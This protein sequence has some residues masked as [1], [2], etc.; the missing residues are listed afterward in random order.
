MAKRKE[1]SCEE[2]MA[3]ARRRETL[4]QAAARVSRNVA[5]I[6][7]PDQLLEQTVDLICDEF[8]FYYAGVFLI[9]ETGEW[10]VLRAGRGEPGRK[11][12]EAGHKLKVDGHSM[13]GRATGERR[14]LIALDVG[15]EPVH[16]KN[17]YLPNTH[18]EMALPLIV[19][20]EL[21]GA[22]TVQS[23]EIAA[24]TDDDIVVLQGM[25]DQLAIAIKNARLHQENQRL[26]ARA[27]RRA[28]L[29]EA[30]AQV[31]RDATSILDLDELLNK[32][33]DIICDAYGFYYAGVF[34]VDESGEWAVLRAG[35]G[36]AG[37]KMIEAGHRLKVGGLSMIGTAIAQRKARIALDV[38]EE[39]VHF[40]NPY[41]PYTRSE[42]ALPLVIGD[43]VIGAITVQSMEEA[44]FSDEDIASLQA[45]ADQVAVAIRNA[46][47]LKDLEE[48]HKELVRTKT[49]EAIATSTLEAIHWIGNKALPITAS[50]E[51]LR[52]D[53]AA[54]REVDAE[55]VNSMME[56]LEIIDESAHLIFQVREHIIGPA[57]EV[58]PGPVMAE[59]VLR[60]AAIALGV[61]EAIITWH[62]AETVPRVWADPLHLSR[63][64]TY[65]LKNALEA[66]EG[67]ESPQIGVE[68][69]PAGNFVAV[70]ITDNGPA[71]PEEVLDKI[72]VP[73]FTTKGRRH[74]GLGLSATMQIIRQLEGK[75]R[76]EN[77][78]EGGVRVEL[79]MPLYDG[80]EPEVE[81][82]EGLKVLLLDD[83]DPWSR[84]AIETWEE[85]ENEVKRATV[86]EK[87]ERYDL[88]IIDDVMAEG[89]SVQL[90]RDLR[91]SGAA[92][93]TVVVA[94][95]L[96]PEEATRLLQYGA[97]DVRPKPYSEAGLAALLSEA[98]PGI[99]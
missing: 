85:A 60:D 70:R 26:L 12:I 74:A 83:D 28:R 72:W 92:R 81:M 2:E 67:M 98:E 78:P 76:V 4:L 14:A 47:L 80:R 33:V 66:V 63:A 9:D 53:L 44:A 5:S 61:D 49:F 52:E 17:P 50:V 99:V 56:D 68:I 91:R 38:G 11:M 37:R 87:P 7:D 97:K 1:R 54:F 95:R 19:G 71:I 77:L 64:F 96:G 90:L 34:L 82:A 58:K 86:L 57:R 43:Q 42:M 8:G 13:I 41:L 51:G 29:L 6:L 35:R 48:A 24:F 22:L 40:K 93:K 73:F 65:V 39:P 18:S 30:A 62:V 20:N 84:F 36:E 15:E 46:Q 69:V 23:E 31:G 21:I 27:Q 94:S 25:A 89:D 88:I 79:L 55:R 10:A 75:A 59:D 3:L 32:V 16:F 45:M